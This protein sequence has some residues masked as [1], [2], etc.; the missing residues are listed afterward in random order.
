[1]TVTERRLACLKYACTG[2]VALHMCTAQKNS[3]GC[4]W[5]NDEKRKLLALEINLA[6]KVEMLGEL[7]N[8]SLRNIVLRKG[9]DQT[10]RLSAIIKY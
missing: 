4:M 9:K 3:F 10:I 5:Y 8:V 7:F 2:G 6:S 1:M